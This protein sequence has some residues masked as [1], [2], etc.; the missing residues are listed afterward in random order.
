MK[1]K[2]R[3]SINF[4]ILL[5]STL[6]PLGRASG[7]ETNQTPDIAIV[8]PH[9][10]DALAGAF[11]IKIKTD[12]SSNAGVTVTQVQFFAE[13]NLIGTVTNAPFK[14]V[15]EVLLPGVDYGYFDLRAVAVD[16]LGRRA[17][18][19]AVRPYYSSTMRGF[20]VVEMLSP[21]NG[22]VFGGPATFVFTA[23][24]FS[25]YGDAGPVEFLVDDNSVGVAQGSPVLRATN[26]PVSV[27]VSN[28][29]QGEHRLQV[30]YLGG[31]GGAC[32]CNWITNKIRVVRLEMRSLAPGHQNNRS[33]VSG[34]G[35]LDADHH[36]SAAR[37]D[38]HFY[39]RLSRH[40]RPSV[41]P[42]GH[43]SSV[44]LWTVRRMDPMTQ[45]TS[46]P[47]RANCCLGSPG[48]RFSP[49]NIRVSGRCTANPCCFAH[50]AAAVF[51]SGMSQKIDCPSLAAT[52]ASITGMPASA[53]V[54]T[55]GPR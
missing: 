50:S 29:A 53:D 6:C 52:R 16:S 37:D 44:G 33:S 30:K 45:P 2:L 51:S 11:P 17:Q 27:V 10:G 34:S 4:G 26:P 1:R 7:A 42:G 25:S 36:Q 19:A 55:T 18:S 31:V 5:L 32:T 46:G 15:W 35:G 23:E 48:A 20:P 43:A 8:W 3:R 9:D 39:R 49:R 12:V 13:T 41:L 24:V 40:K 47:A 21:R 28:L 22:S 14:L 54:A 38:F